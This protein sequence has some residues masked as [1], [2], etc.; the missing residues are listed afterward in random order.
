MPANLAHAQD[1]EENAIADFW[2]TEMRKC[3]FV[4]ERRVQMKED[5][6][7]EELRKQIEQAK[8]DAE[9]DKLEDADQE[10]ELAE[11]DAY[12][13]Q[14]LVMKHKLG[15]INDEQL[16]SMQEERKKKKAQ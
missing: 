9:K 3:D 13:D 14:L 11:E 16:Q 2:D 5:F 1:D 10:K 6:Q 8:K 12:Q 15:L 4:R 7:A